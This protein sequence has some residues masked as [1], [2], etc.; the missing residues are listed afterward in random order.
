MSLTFLLLLASWAFIIMLV[1]ERNFTLKDIG[2]IKREVMRNRDDIIYLYDL[3]GQR[4]WHQHIEWSKE[5]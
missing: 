2:R 4:Q 1:I 5:D 3:Q